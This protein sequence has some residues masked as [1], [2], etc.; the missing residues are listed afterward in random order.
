MMDPVRGP[1]IT[2]DT[3]LDNSGWV[4]ALALSLVRDEQRAD[5]LVQETWLRALQTPPT[6]VETARGWLATV[7]RNLVRDGWKK[8][9]R[10][11]AREAA[12]ARH[13]AL[14]P[15]AD[16]V[17]RAEAHRTLIRHVTRL[18]EPY[19][20]VVLLRFF[21]DLPPREIAVRLSIPPATV[22]TRLHRALGMLRTSLDA[23]GDGRSEWALAL[24]PLP[25]SVFGKGVVLG[26][27]GGS[28]S[29]VI[30]GLA[31]TTKQKIAVAAT[32]MLLLCG[33]AA[34]FAATGGVDPAPADDDAAPETAA[35]TT[36]AD[37]D[38]KRVEPPAAEPRAAPAP[39]ADD[40]EPPVPPAAPPPPPRRARLEYTV[41][42]HVG[43]REVPKGYTELQPGEEPVIP[44]RGDAQGMGSA[45]PTLLP[46]WS[47][48]APVPE[49]GSVTVMGRVTDASGRP[50]EG[51]QVYR[52][53]LDE[54]GQRGSPSSYQ[55]IDEIAVTDAGGNYVAEEQPSGDFLIAADFRATMRRR[56]G[57]DITPAVPVNITS[58]QRMRGVDVQLPVESARL[59]TVRFLVK[60][61]RG[62][63]MRNA[64]IRAPM[65]RLYTDKDGRATLGGLQPGMTPVHISGTGY[66]TTKLEM[67]LQPGADDDVEVQLDFAEKGDLVLEGRV[68]DEEGRPVANAPIF[69]GASYKGSRWAKT[70]DDGVFRFEHVSRKYEKTQVSVMVSPHPERDRF[71]P[72]GPPV[73][74]TVPAPGLE[75]VVRRTA[76]LHVLLRDEESGAPLSLY[77]ISTQIHSVVDG[78]EQWRNHHGMSHYDESGE[79]V[80]MVPKGRFRLTIRAKDHRGVEVEVDMPDAMEDREILVEMERE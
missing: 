13:E 40:A 65:E 54:N 56:R 41:L 64:E 44:D 4:R 74:T 45:G 28:S 31:V 49:K 52:V 53:E 24:L 22:R 36:D 66:A 5:D 58:M 19:R 63:P 23:S 73:K 9:G 37:S 75:L 38:R 55:W 59:A 2:L 32:L 42:R 67:D 43:P 71:K 46:Y 27:G 25:G 26:H 6:R 35:A 1:A 57:L 72:L 3:L 33:G 18:A 62:E 15:A 80:F 17:A 78:E 12:V 14:P 11:T 70:G 29:A 34:W 8:D 61:E 7:L 77:A 30:G 39:V 69:I 21:E 79:A 50:L 20:T 48:W 47:R 60:N 10:R 16:L 76:K 68:V 51:A